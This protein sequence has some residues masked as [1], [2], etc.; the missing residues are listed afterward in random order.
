MSES[1]S[2]TVPVWLFAGL[3]GA[4]LGAGIVSIVDGRAGVGF[5]ASYDLGG[6]AS[7]KFGIGNSET[8]FDYTDETEGTNPADDTRSVMRD[9][10]TDAYEWSLGVA[11]KF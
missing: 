11:F 9:L 1:T 2:P 6:G 8:E 4:L 7:I 3:F 5:G 10:D